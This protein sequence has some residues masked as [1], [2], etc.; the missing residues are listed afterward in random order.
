MHYEGVDPA[1]GTET[2]AAIVI[3][4]DGPRW[5]GTRFLLRAGKA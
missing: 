5:T 1:R 4:L 3:E 2:F